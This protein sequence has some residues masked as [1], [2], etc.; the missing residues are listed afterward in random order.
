MGDRFDGPNKLFESLEHQHQLEGT[1][2]HA[3]EWVDSVA[4]N[5]GNPSSSGREPTSSKMHPTQPC[6]R[7]AVN[8]SVYDSDQPLQKMVAIADKERG[9]PVKTQLWRK[10]KKSGCFL[11]MSA[12]MTDSSV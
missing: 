3:Q 1:L 10:G 8:N 5:Q 7:K 11:E 12:Y 2:A 4:L 9:R 6:K